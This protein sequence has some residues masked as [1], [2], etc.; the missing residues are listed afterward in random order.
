MKEG[1]GAHT[2]APQHRIH[3]DKGEASALEHQK[4]TKKVKERKHL[5]T[6]N[7]TL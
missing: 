5:A 2:S 3:F 7:W 1:S 6:S 4:S